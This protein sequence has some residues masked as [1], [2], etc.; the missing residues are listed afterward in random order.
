[1]ARSG[2]MVVLV[3]EGSQLAGALT[4]PDMQG[5]QLAEDVLGPAAANVTT[6]ISPNDLMHSGSWGAYAYA[7][8]TAVQ[9][10]RE[11]LHTHGR[12]DPASILDLPCGH[13]R[14]LRFLKLAYPDAR[15]GV[16][17]IDADGVDFCARTFGA[18]PIVS[19]DNPAA[20]SFD[21]RYELA[22]SGSLFTHLSA[23]RWQGFLEMYARALEPGGLLLFSANGYLPPSILRDLGLNADQ[24]E[25]LLDDFRTD[26]FG[27]VSTGQ[28]KW[29]L[30]LARPLWVKEQIDRSPLELLS[31]E[32]RAWKPPS[33]AQDVV[34]CTLPAS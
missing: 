10:I 6:E 23:E 3:V 28:G 5:H 21:Q 19:N 1:M 31:Y 20:V 14:E 34:V 32:K 24:A 17:D 29:G 18:D 11:V 16:C 33:P 22:W 4:L 7:G 30:S 15:M 27:F 26:H 12:P 9:A 2:Y 8:V 13:G 25:Q